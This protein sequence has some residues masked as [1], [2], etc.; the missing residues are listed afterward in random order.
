MRPISLRRV[1]NAMLYS[2]GLTVLVN[3]PLLLVYLYGKATRPSYPDDDFRD[4]CLEFIVDMVIFSLVMIG[5][6]IYTNQASRLPK[7]IEY[8]RDLPAMSPGCAAFFADQVDPGPEGVSMTGI[9]RSWAASATLLQL[10]EKKYIAIYPGV[11]ADYEGFDLRR[12]DDAGLRERMLQIDEAQRS[13]AGAARSVPPGA[14][15]GTSYGMTSG[16]S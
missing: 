8:S 9:V 14:M 7:D 10:R 1:M 5:V 13:S 15:P 2:L 6:A 12:P 3:G 4:H 16:Q 11:A